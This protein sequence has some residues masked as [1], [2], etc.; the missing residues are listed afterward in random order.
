MDI[1][2]YIK[3]KKNND[4]KKS[5]CRELNSRPLPYQGNALPLSYIGNCKKKKKKSER[6]GSNWRHSAWKA[7]ALPTELLSQYLFG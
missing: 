4:L 2:N 6:P 5:Q 7:D 3:L 1:H